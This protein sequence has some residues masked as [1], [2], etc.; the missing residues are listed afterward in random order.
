MVAFPSLEPYCADSTGTA[1]PTAADWCS[2]AWCW[3]DPANCDI[4]SDPSSYF[5]VEGQDAVLHY[6][7]GT[8][9]ADNTFTDS[10]LDAQACN[11]EHSEVVAEHCAGGIQADERCPCVN[12]ADEPDSRAQFENDDGSA[13]IVPL[14]GADY[15]YALGYGSGACAAHDATHAPYCADANGAPLAGAPDWCQASWCWVDPNNCVLA[16]AN[17]EAVE[18]VASSYFHRD[19]EEASRYYSYETCQHDNTFSDTELDPQACNDEHSEV[20][21]DH[22]QVVATQDALTT[23]PCITMP[24]P[25][26]FA[27]DASDPPMVTVTIGGESYPYPAGYGIGAC[28]P[29]DQTQAPSCANADGSVKADAPSWCS[30]NWCFVDPAACTGLAADSTEPVESTYFHVDGQEATFYCECS[31]DLMPS[32]GST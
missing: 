12:W 24:D 20:V 18:A 31:A 29:H 19:G 28:A 5:H 27:I 13:L 3:V 14:E 21:A 15:T 16:D 2:S 25:H 30:S 6:S 1:L 32:A 10:E 7:Y 4:E 26:P 11:E 17:G 9:G 22:C 23:C 8:C